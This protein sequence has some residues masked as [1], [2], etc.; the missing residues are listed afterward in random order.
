MGI[1]KKVVQETGEA[2]REVYNQAEKTTRHVLEPTAKAVSGYVEAR[3]E[4]QRAEREARV[5]QR[6]AQIKREHPKVPSKKAIEHARNEEE[7]GM[8]RD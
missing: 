5:M 3:G 1:S 7:A 4:Q 8:L 2:L 6:A